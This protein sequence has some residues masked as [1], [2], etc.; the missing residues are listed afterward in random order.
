MEPRDPRLFDPG[1]FD[2][3]FE[4]HKVGF[5]EQTPIGPMVTDDA[6]Y[7]EPADLTPAERG[8][9]LLRSW[10]I[11]TDAPSSSSVS[12]IAR[13]MPLVEPV[14][15]ARLPVSPRSMHAPS[16]AEGRCY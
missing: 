12:A 5:P 7:V 9:W 6:N 1:R 4:I 14:T 10:Q 8:F 2:E 11:A 3:L 16:T 15:M 13:P